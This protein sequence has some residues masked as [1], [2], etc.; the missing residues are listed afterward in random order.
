MEFKIAREEIL[1]GLGLTQSIVEKKNTIQILSNV[2]LKSEQD[3]L[4]IEATDLE[5]GIR[6]T[7]T[8]EGIIE[9]GITVD[10]KMLYE[11]VRQIP[12]GMTIHFKK[13]EN[14]WVEINAGRSVFNLVG[15]SSEDFPEVPL[16]P[17]DYQW[18]MEPPVIESMVDKT[19]FAVSHE[20]VRYNLSGVYCE[21]VEESGGKTLR[22][23]A[24]DGHRLS[25]VETAIDGEL[26]EVLKKGIILPRKGLSELKKMLDEGEDAIG[27]RVE[28]NNLMVHRDGTTLVMRLI[29]GRFPDY[30]QVIPQSNDKVITFPR[31]EFIR[32]L[33]RVSILSYD[34]VRMV[35]FHISPNMVEISSESPEMGTAREEVPVEYSGNEFEIGFNANYILD[36]LNA[37][38]DDVVVFRLLDDSSPGEVR[39]AEEKGYFFI[40]MPMKI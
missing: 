14:N 16:F 3:V 6:D 39:P 20:D 11:V 29:D 12:D 18:F 27:M 26:P 7:Y 5:V 32:T 9:G 10:A 30:R 15:L 2:L 37:V 17:G 24:T 23:V 25:L 22:M 31:E 38:D 33:R 36:I 35:K 4:T 28:E 19:I 40:I 8:C 34:R 13:Q 1:R 21:A